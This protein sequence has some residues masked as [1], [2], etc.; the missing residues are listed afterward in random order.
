[1]VQNRETFSITYP[2]S[3][4][5]I[6]FLRDK[7]CFSFTNLSDAP[8]LAPFPAASTLPWAMGLP[9]P[10]EDFNFFIKPR[11]ASPDGFDGVSPLRGEEF[12][13]VQPTRVIRYLQQFSTDVQALRLT[14]GAGGWA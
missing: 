10:S 12:Y 5:A 8:G 3:N 13:R 7:K 2:T 1:M 14:T 11:L 4:E 9:S 6:K